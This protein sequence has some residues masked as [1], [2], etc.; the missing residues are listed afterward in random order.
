MKPRRPPVGISAF[1][2]LALV[3]GILLVIRLWLD[4]HLELMYNEAYYALWAKHLAWGYFDHPPMVAL[5]IR[6]STICFGDHEFGVRALGTLSATAET[7]L[8]YLLSWHL[9]GRQSEAI[10]A[11]LLFCA[12]LLIS[13]GA[14][15]IAPDTPLVFFWS[16][17]L[18]A[19]VRIFCGG[20]S[21]WRFEP[22]LFG[23]IFGKPAWS[24]HPIRV[25]A[26]SG[27]SMAGAETAGRRER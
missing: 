27:R 1:T 8:I 2:T 19:L 9:F 3:T 20:G 18:Y 24:A 23:R 6:L 22:S 12:M 25:R 7:A 11:A 4:S 10:F 14:I 16:I 15:I 26:R 17:A 21:G 13:A 5:W